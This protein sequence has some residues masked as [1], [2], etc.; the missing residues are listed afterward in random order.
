MGAVVVSKAIAAYDLKPS[1]VILEMPFASLQTHLRA[2]ARLLGFGGVGEKPFG[3][4]VTLWIGLERGFNG[5]KDQ[6]SRYVSKMSCPVLMQWGDAD[7]IVLNSETD[8]IYHAIASPQKKLVIYEN[9]GHESLLQKD[10][11]RWRMEVEGFL[12]ANNR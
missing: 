9:A 5:F 1:G 8:R 3:F 12:L 11:A 7:N 4:L 2:R 6:T 10:P